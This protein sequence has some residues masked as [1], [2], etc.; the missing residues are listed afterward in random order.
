VFGYCRG[1]SIRQERCYFTMRSLFVIVHQP[2]V[3]SHVG[4]QYRRQPALDPDWP[5]LH[6]GPQS[7]LSHILY[8]GSD[9]V[10]TGF[11]GTHP[12]VDHCALTDESDHSFKGRLVQR[13]LVTCSKND[14]HD[15]YQPF[16][17]QFCCN[18]QRRSDAMVW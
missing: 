1:H 9:H 15:P 8:D 16:D 2:R 5:L 4:G 13:K 17:D 11:G 12:D 10:P 7:N 14:A 3:T 6:H 18:A